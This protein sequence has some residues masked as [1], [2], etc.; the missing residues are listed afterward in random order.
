MGS[1]S[2]LPK[3]E[4]MEEYCRIKNLFY[5]FI[6]DD[7]YHDALSLAIKTKYNKELTESEKVKLGKI[8][9]EEFRKIILY[10]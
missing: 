8:F 3:G 7:K 5:E 9:S 2:P 1:K 10:R 6:E 4:L